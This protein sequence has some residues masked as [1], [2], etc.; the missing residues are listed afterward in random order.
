[1]GRFPNPADM[2]SS[3]FILFVETLLAIFLCLVISPG[4]KWMPLVVHT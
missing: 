3:P 1:M 2:V 4:K